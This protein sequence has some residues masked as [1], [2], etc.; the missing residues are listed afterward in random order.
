MVL[1]IYEQLRTKGGSMKC[2]YAHG[3]PQVGGQGPHKAKEVV[4]AAIRKGVSGRNAPAMAQ[5]SKRGR[6][7]SPGRT[8]RG[9]HLACPWV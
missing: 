3:P 4:M 2:W 7:Q 1:A 8:S 6:L 9:F 5:A